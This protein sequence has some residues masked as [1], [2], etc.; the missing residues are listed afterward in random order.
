VH[1]VLMASGSWSVDT[2]GP[3]VLGT[4]SWPNNIDPS[5][6]FQCPYCKKW[7]YWSQLIY[8]EGWCEECRDTHDAVICPDCEEMT[9]LAFGGYQEIGYVSEDEN[10]R[11]GGW[12]WVV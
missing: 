9:I 6:F 10:E 7:F 12:D 2:Y 5:I 4:I 1:D 3:T 8:T 11:G